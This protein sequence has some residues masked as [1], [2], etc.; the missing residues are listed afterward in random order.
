[1]AERD[2]GDGA[3]ED[4]HADVWVGVDVDLHAGVTYLH[5]YLM[6]YLNT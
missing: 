6:Q 5:M 1:M 4:A 2:V 3:D